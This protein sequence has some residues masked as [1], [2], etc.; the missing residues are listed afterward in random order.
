MQKKHLGYI[1]A[2]CVSLI[3]ILMLSLNVMA[4]ND[5]QG[6]Q[7]PFI[8]DKS[9]RTILKEVLVNQ[10]KTHALLKDIKALLQEAK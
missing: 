8:T 6:G 9:D 10:R 7:V 3:F 1:I 2:G 4:A 5:S